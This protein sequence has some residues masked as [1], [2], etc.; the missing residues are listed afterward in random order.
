MY[1]FLAGFMCGVYLG[2]RYDLETYVIAVET[3]VSSLAHD[4]EKR[5]KAGADKQEEQ[6]KE[7]GGFVARIFGSEKKSP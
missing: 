1:Q 4:L 2:T 5:R 3:R 6:S 7:T